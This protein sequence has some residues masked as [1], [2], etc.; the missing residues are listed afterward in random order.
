[1]SASSPEWLP[2]DDDARAQIL[3]ALTPDVGP[4]LRGRL[5]ERFGDAARVFAAGDLVERDRSVTSAIAS[6]RRAAWGVDAALRG[7]AEAA[8]RPPPPRPTIAAVS[9]S[10]A[11]RRS[12]PDRRVQA[13]LLPASTRTGSFDEVEGR[14]SEEAARREAERCLVCGQ[15]GNCSVCTEVVGC[16][17]FYVEGGKGLYIHPNV[18]HEAVFPLAARASFY[19]EQG[20]VHARISCNIA[21][22]FGVFL[23]V[24]LRGVR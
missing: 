4:I 12:D 3:L 16:P 24:P 13:P 9:S 15:C 20:K 5:L 11:P 8:R 19:D 7:S 17:A 6:G 23:N 14:I 22:E 21:K 2:I 10:F 18:W 1:M